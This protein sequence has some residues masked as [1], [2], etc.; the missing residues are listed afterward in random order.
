MYATYYITLCCP[1]AHSSDNKILGVGTYTEK[2][3][4][5]ALTTYTSPVEAF[6]TR[7]LKFI[8]HIYYSLAYTTGGV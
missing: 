3:L 8:Y 1:H 7:V 2:V 4:V 5:G 6:A